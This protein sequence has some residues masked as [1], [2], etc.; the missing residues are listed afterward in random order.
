VSPLCPPA[1]V[2]GSVEPTSC[3]I[4][5]RV[6]GV[7]VPP[8]ASEVPAR[9][10][11]P[12]AEGHAER[13]R[14]S[15]TQAARMWRCFV[16]PYPVVL[17][18]P[19]PSSPPAAT[20]PTGTV[21]SDHRTAPSREVP[22]RRWL[23]SAL[24]RSAGTRQVQG[25]PAKR[26]PSHEDARQAPAGACDDRPEPSGSNRRP[27]RRGLRPE[28]CRHTYG[29]AT[30]TALHLR[31]DAADEHARGE[32]DPSDPDFRCKSVFRTST[33]AVSTHSGVTV[34]VSDRVTRPEERSGIAEGLDDRLALIMLLALACGVPLMSRWRSHE[35]R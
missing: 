12:Q 32:D 21:S 10:Y 16:V 5:I 1:R 34:H 3:G 6:S 28:R 33:H 18:F 31:A 26:A 13:F 9:R 29:D 2:L 35:R 4:I 25:R 14:V 22:R 27:P 11:F 7:R 20:P 15:R 24:R 17:T 8:P 23:H 19:S 30:A